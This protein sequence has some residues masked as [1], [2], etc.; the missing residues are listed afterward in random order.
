[1]P[2]HFINLNCTGCGGELEAYD[3]IYAGC[4]RRWR[5]LGQI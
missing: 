1:M 4:L 5:H 3:D 2:D